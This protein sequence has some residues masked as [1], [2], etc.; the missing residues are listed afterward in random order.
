MYYPDLTPYRYL[1]RERSDDLLNI[2]WL[3]IEHPFPRKKA[4]EI[5][6]DALFDRCLEPVLQMRGFHQCEFCDVPKFAPINVSRNGQQVALGSAE[7][8]VTGKDGRTYAAPNM[9]YHYVAAHDYDPPAEFIEA[10]MA[11]RR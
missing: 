6:L 8:R 9:I 11:S 1:E 10:L 4:P 2:G 3:A 5:L 7:I